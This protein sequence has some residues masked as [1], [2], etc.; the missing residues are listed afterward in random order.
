MPVTETAGHF[1]FADWK[2]NP[3]SPED[4][5]PRLAHATVVNAFTGVVEAEATVCSYAVAYDSAATG[6]FAGM[7]LVTG[8]VDGRSG[9]FV[10][11][12]R[13]AS[14]TTAPCTARSR[15]SRAPAPGSW[16]GCAARAGSP[17][18]T[19][20]RRCRTPSRTRWGAPES[21]AWLGET[22]TVYSGPRFARAARGASL[23]QMVRA[24]VL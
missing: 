16:P 9:A 4:A 10:L 13:G 14:P 23:A 8:R 18:G 1:T 17:T 19:V 24:A 5:F 2:E 22:G 6:T 11:E 15:W 20:R 3:V 21:S 7:E 12:E